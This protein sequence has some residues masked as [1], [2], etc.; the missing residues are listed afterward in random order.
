MWAAAA[1]CR[2]DRPAK[3]GNTPDVLP[4]PAGLSCRCRHEAVTR[5]PVAA[6]AR[7]RMESMEPVVAAMPEANG[8]AGWAKQQEPCR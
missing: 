7:A 1:V 3:L 8:P 2:E 6:S 5:N 4:G